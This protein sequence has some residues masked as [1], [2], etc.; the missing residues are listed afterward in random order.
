[1]RQNI[2]IFSGYCIMSLIVFNLIRFFFLSFSLSRFCSYVLN[3]N[4]EFF[5]LRKTQVLFLV[6]NMQ[7]VKV[8][9][10][11]NLENSKDL[12]C[13]S[14]KKNSRNFGCKKW[15]TEFNV[16]QLKTLTLDASNLLI[17]SNLFFFVL[18]TFYFSIFVW[19]VFISFEWYTKHTYSIR[20]TLQ[21]RWNFSVFQRITRLNDK[22]KKFITNFTFFFA[23]NCFTSTME[24]RKNWLSIFSSSWNAQ[25]CKER[26]RAIN[27][28]KEKRDENRSHLTML[29][30]FAM[31]FRIDVKCVCVREVLVLSCISLTTH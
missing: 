12:L 28:R 24:A 5:F 31:D 25:S 20:W 19:C 7:T 3:R 6:N 23:V 11:F 13:N 30:L 18:N 1:M 27:S 10:Q 26:Q 4:F 14:R 8:V 15:R 29:V 16:S 9:K 17:H 21:L 2:H 22:M